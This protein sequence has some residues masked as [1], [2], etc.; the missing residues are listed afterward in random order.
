MPSGP[1]RHASVSIV[2]ERD[3]YSSAIRCTEEGF[4]ARLSA[5]ESRFIRD[6]V[7]ETDW[8]DRAYIGDLLHIQETIRTRGPHGMAH[9]LAYRWAKDRLP[10]EHDCIK[11]EITDGVYTPRAEF[12]ELQ[13]A[14]REQEAARTEARRA[15]QE[16]KLLEAQRPSHA[17]WRQLG[18]R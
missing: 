12:R 8:T 3:L 10:T 4:A 7:V 13:R 2:S 6:R 11:R 1:L 18:G 17:L 16:A 15:D 14:R 5:T 9:A